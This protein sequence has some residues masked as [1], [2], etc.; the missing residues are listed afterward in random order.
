VLERLVALTADTH[1]DVRQ[2]AAEALGWL[3]KAATTP[4]VLERL[5]ALT[6]DTHD[7]VRWAAA[8]ALGKMEGAESL[9][10]YLAHLWQTYLTIS[11]YESIGNHFGRVCDIAYTQLQQTVARRG[12][13]AR[14]PRSSPE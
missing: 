7:D 12:A 11:K 14:E 8:S 1:D 13:R 2:A 4:V 3:G 10:E 5:V 9:L 6:A